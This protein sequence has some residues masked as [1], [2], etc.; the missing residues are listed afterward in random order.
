MKS[1]K[2][3]TKHSSIC[4]MLSV[5]K[6][7]SFYAKKTCLITSSKELQSMLGDINYCKTSLPNA[8]LVSYQK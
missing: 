3:A 1:A 7:A 5:R 4:F 6:Q 8:G 2:I